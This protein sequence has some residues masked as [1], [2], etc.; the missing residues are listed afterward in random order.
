M[1]FLALPA[2]L[3]LALTGAAAR[4]AEPSPAEIRKEM[5]EIRQATNWED[6]AAAEAAE[7][8]L[9]VLRRCLLREGPSA[10]GLPAPPGAGGES[11]TALEDRPDNRGA[12]GH[13]D[14][15][16]RIAEGV[17]TGGHTVDLGKTIRQVIDD[18]LSEDRDFTPRNRELLEQLDTLILDLST[19]EGRG[20]A[21]R[22]DAFRGVKRLIVTGGSA[23]AP[24]ALDPLLA[25]GAALPLEE[26]WVV[27][28]HGYLTTLSPRVAAFH[29]LRKLG[30]FGNGLSD[31]PPALGGL[32]GLEELLVDANPITTVL[33]VAS[34]LPRLARLGIGGTRI[35]AAERAAL[36]KLLPR[37]RIEP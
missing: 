33:P 9:Q 24:I 3:A 2:L 22:L 37:C 17:A 19:P 35:G 13:A 1:R 16:E 10:K 29:G 20:L 23:G 34:R 14:M 21:A 27:D 15:H 11:G 4:A 8:R 31:L 36:R 5:L 32:S 7:A 28:F 26:L 18:K 25:L 6:P 12:G 30:L